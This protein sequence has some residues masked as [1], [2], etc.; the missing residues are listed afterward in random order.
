MIGIK[1][2]IVLSIAGTSKGVGRAEYRGFITL[3]QRIN[4]FGSEYPYNKNWRFEEVL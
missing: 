1:N 3:S 2:F 4:L